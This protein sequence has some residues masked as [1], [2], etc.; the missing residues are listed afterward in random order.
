MKKILLSLLILA[1][2][3]SSGQNNHPAFDAKTW[4]PP[5]Q[6]PVPQGWEAE[7]FPVPPAFATQIRLTGVEDV[8]FTPGWANAKTDEYWTYAFLWF[9]DGSPTLNAVTFRSDLKAYYSGLIK[10]NIDPKKIPSGGIMHTEAVIK[11]MHRMSGDRNTF[12]GTVS[13][14]DYMQQKPIILNCIIHVR[15]Y[16]A[17]DKTIVFCELSPKDTSNK[18]WTGLNKLWSDF[19]YE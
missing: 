17:M 18:V 19:V 2:I 15:R 7:R 4:K 3:K 16:P 10:T 1:V 9:L 6:L 8:R 12:S 5:Y 13:M 14:L 11:K